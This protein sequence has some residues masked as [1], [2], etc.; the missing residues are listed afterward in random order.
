MGRPRWWAPALGV[1]VLAAGPCLLRAGPP[2]ADARE[3]AATIDRLVAARWAARGVRPAEPADDA[4][5]LRRVSLDLAG[6]IPRAWDVRAFL[7]DPAPD[8]RR[9]LVDRLLDGPA[10]VNHFTNVWRAVLLPE[11]NNPQVRLLLPSFESW[12]RERVRANAPYDRVVR[13]LLT[14]PIASGDRPNGLPGAGEL[15]PVAFYQAGEL[16]AENLAGSTSRIFLG[17]KLECAQCHDHPFARWSR[18]QFWEYAAFFSG[19]QPAGPYG[20]F[21]AV[22]DEADRHE[23]KI[24]GT[25][26]QVEARLPDGTRPA[27]KPGVGARATLADWVTAADNPF[28]ARA[29]ANRLWAQFFGT[30]LIDPVDEPGE[31][32]P[33]SHPEL[34]DELARQLIT[35]G[36]DL[37]FLIRAIVLSR[38]YQLGSGAVSPGPDDPRLF[39]RMAVRGLTPE[40]LFDSLVEATGYR[41]PAAAQ[42]RVFRPGGNTPRAEFLTRFASQ[43]RGTQAQ[44]SILQA[45]MLM[46]GPFVADATSLERSETLAAVIDAPFL[47]SPAERIEALYLATLSRKP[48]PDELARLVPY[49]ARGGPKGDS[50]AALADVFWA[51]LNSS[52]FVLNH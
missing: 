27:W 43:D 11:S 3:L 17:V 52:E 42:P 26:K 50:K 49:V 5:F 35:H 21:G 10:Y 28:F 24:P 20:L 7:D 18:R 33:P 51:L 39:A 40:Q 37:K 19:I 4:E 45:L 6:K 13:E 23:L 41:A 25:A 1:L 36:F 16:K 47:K 48:R 38:T 34:L 22:Q 44:T 31:Q 12:L 9:R 15:T 14:L 8:K 2:Q 46:N 32:N 30:G 29:V